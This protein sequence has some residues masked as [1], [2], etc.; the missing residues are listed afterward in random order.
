QLELV[1]RAWVVALWLTPRYRPSGSV[2]TLIIGQAKHVPDDNPERDNFVPCP[3]DIEKL[4]NF[5]KA[6]PTTERIQ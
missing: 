4:E 5:R 3:A 2:H 1:D 6:F